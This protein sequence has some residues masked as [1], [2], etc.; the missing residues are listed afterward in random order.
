MPS[1]TDAVRIFAN[2]GREQR[3]EQTQDGRIKFLRHHDPSIL[4][5]QMRRRRL[6]DVLVGEHGKHLLQE[7]LD[8]LVLLVLEFKLEVLAISHRLIHLIFV[9]EVVVGFL[10]IHSIPIIVV[11]HPVVELHGLLEDV[12]GMAHPRF[13]TPFGRCLAQF[14][15]LPHHLDEFS[16]SNSKVDLMVVAENV[17]II[18][19][20]AFQSFINISI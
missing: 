11:T 6:P 12:V 13:G 20:D 1:E 15:G 17:R 18:C 16:A 9:L 2:F 19:I 3:W 8:L 14:G 5:Q 4:L 7:I 10:G